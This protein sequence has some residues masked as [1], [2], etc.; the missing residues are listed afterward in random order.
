MVQRAMANTPVAAGR[1]GIRRVAMGRQ[2][3]PAETRTRGR[4]LL[5]AY[6]GALLIPGSFFVAGLDLSL[7][8]AVLLLSVI[9]TGA[10][11]DQGQGGPGDPG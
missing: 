10:R 3:A 9:P 7:L 8:R 6:F 2:E 5:L 4:P 11:L 1:S